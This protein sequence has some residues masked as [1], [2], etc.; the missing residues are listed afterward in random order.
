MDCIGVAESVEALVVCIIRR[1]QLFTE[2]EHCYCNV[3]KTNL[4]C[5][6]CACVYIS[7]TA[8]II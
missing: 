1:I 7:I 3:S 4:R 5:Y 8:I 6:D 2:T